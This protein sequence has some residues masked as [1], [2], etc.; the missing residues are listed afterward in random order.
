MSKVIASILLAVVLFPEGAAALTILTVGY[1]CDVSRIEI[2]QTARTT[3][4]TE[5]TGYSSPGCNAM[6]DDNAGN[7]HVAGA[8]VHPATTNRI[9]SIDKVTGA[10]T[11]MMDLPPNLVALKDIRGLAAGDEGMLYALAV[12]DANIPNRSVTQ[13][14]AIDLHSEAV[15][16]VSSTMGHG[17][18]GIER[19]ADG[20]IY[21]WHLALQLVLLDQ[22]SGAWIDVDP[23]DTSLGNFRIQALAA[24]PD[25][26]LFGAREGSLYLIDRDTGGSTLFVS[27][28]IQ[29][30]R[31]M[32]FVIPEPTAIAIVT[33]L[34]GGLNVVRTRRVH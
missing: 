28:I 1:N 12:I 33:I 7:V 22:A 34:F 15:S 21:G 5:L 26:R 4:I 29:D 17:I 24:S 30:I 20:A 23:S 18:Q 27:D 8:A 10:R 13:L 11:A 6:A 14:F 25:G 31:G 16:L 32:A 2:D 3:M 9:Y 19:M